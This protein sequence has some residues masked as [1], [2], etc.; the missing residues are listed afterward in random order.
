VGAPLPAE[1]GLV[2][3]A[4][5]PSASTHP[6]GP[7]R[8]GG[9]GRAPPIRSPPIQTKPSYNGPTPAW[10]RVSF[11]VGLAG[12]RRRRRLTW[13]AGPGDAAPARRPVGDDPP[14]FLFPCPPAADGASDGRLATAGSTGGEDAAQANGARTAG[15]NRAAETRR[16]ATALAPPVQAGARRGAKRRR[17]HRRFQPAARARRQSDGRFAPPGSAAA[18]RGR[19]ATALPATAGST[20]AKDAGASDGRFAPF[21]FSRRKTRP[22]NGRK[23]RRPR[24]QPLPSA[25]AIFRARR[26]PRPSFRPRPTRRRPARRARYPGLA[27][28][29]LGREEATQPQDGRTN[30]G[31]GPPIDA[32]RTCRG[33]DPAAALPKPGRAPRI[34]G[35]RPAVGRWRAAARRRMAAVRSPCC[36]RGGAQRATD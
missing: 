5:R 12:R 20:V 9:A 31:Q 16:Q 6:E 1:P 29:G 18:R 10:L 25:V 15:S 2:G 28:A 23:R 32:H 21:G 30:L 3:L 13:F 27:A 34:R 14:A 22:S 19:K 36:R 7:S 24:R 26:R 33:L 35:E 4:S 8:S 11:V 17:S